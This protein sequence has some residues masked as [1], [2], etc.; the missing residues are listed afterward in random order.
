VRTDG[1]TAAGAV[2]V[3]LVEIVTGLI[4]GLTEFTS[5]DGREAA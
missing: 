5:P 4:R 1:T 3:E 2:V